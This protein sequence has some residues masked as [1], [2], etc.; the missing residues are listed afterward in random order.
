M[1]KPEVHV[2][3]YTYRI[4]TAI[5]ICYGPIDK[6]Y[7]LDFNSDFEIYD[8]SAGS[9]STP[10]SFSTGDNILYGSLHWGT[11]DQG[12]DYNLSQMH[13]GSTLY[14]RNVCYASFHLDLGHGPS[15]PATAFT[16]ARWPDV[17]NDN[18][19]DQIFSTSWGFNP[20]S[21][22][23]D[24]L[25]NTIYGFAIAAT[26]IDT[27]SFEDARSTVYSEGFGFST[28]I[29]SG[30]LY[31]VI[32]S[33]LDWM[34]GEL[35]YD[36]TSGKIKL[37]LRREDYNE[38]E[39]IE[40]T[41]SDMRAQ[42]FDL[43]RPSWYSTKNVIYVAFSDVYRECDQN[44]VYSEDLGNF[45]L[46]NN[47]RVQE[48]NFDVFIDSDTAQRVANR[49]LSKNSYPYARV[50]FECFASKGESIKIFDPIRVRHSYYGVDAIFRVTEKRYEG[51][52][53][54]K[55]EAVEEKFPATQIYDVPAEE[56]YDPYV[57]GGY[58][59]KYTV[60][61][62]Y[63]YLETKYRGL[64]ILGYT[65]DG[66][67][68]CTLASFRVDTD[69]FAETKRYG[70][71]GLLASSLSAD[72][73]ATIYITLDKHFE[74]DATTLKYVLI[75]DEIF[76]IDSA[77]LDGD[78]IV[79]TS[80]LSNRG[81]EETVKA[82]HLAGARVFVIECRAI[83]SSSQIPDTEL[84]YTITPIY[85]NP[86]PYADRDG[87]QTFDYTYQGLIKKPSPP[88]DI[89]TSPS[90]PTSHDDITFSWLRDNRV[91]PIPVPCAGLSAYPT[92]DTGDGLEDQIYGWRLKYFTSAG[93][94]P[95]LTVELNPSVMSH[96]STVTDRAA[97]GMTYGA[98]RLEVYAMG[99]YGYD[100]GPA[101]YEI[102]S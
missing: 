23:Y 65:P 82:T 99:L 12:N 83:G 6:F 92:T 94:T 60:T 34:D 33:A 47:L 101:T 78:Y 15:M 70:S 80:S 42:T 63:R 85:S 21:V 73:D 102:M 74:Q 4:R 25:T 19:L 55:I 76:G 44:I 2:Y 17:F 84:T 11:S 32:R 3:T 97:A 87:S 79:Y 10:L 57:S 75:D 96:T 35:L 28:C 81:L 16:V 37:R 27:D 50:S 95:N 24:L 13:G 20:A 67:T 41:Q 88:K 5:A 29:Q 7:R 86:T 64:L 56:P 90:S 69:Y 9:G 14:Y 31:T 38:A 46:T 54:W 77:E 62:Y 30:D 100:G 36:E 93:V 91:S 39:L 45:N 18:K 48:F 40:V 66:T 71:V 51:A 72:H 8:A 53:L 68:P 1:G 26:Y 61:W 59:E 98:F 22:V 58:T 52:N 43:T 89:S 49:L